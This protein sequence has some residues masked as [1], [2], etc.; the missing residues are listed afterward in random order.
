MD[1]PSKYK[2]KYFEMPS[3][4]LWIFEHDEKREI[5]LTTAERAWR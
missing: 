1:G 5:Y 3:I 4:Q 2:E